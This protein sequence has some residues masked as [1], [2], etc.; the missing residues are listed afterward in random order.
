M[1]FLPFPT[2]LTDA[3]FFFPY[4]IWQLRRRFAIAVEGKLHN[5]FRTFIQLS[6]SYGWN[7]LLAA[8]SVLWEGQEIRLEFYAEHELVPRK[9]AGRITGTWLTCF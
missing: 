4:T 2:S 7:D 5:D 1:G 8:C 3:S 9:D 6:K